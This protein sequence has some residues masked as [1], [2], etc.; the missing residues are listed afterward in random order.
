MHLFGNVSQI[1]NNNRMKIAKVKENLQD[2][3]KKLHCRRDELKNLWLQGL[4]YKHMLQ[5]LD[6]M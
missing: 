3:K 1:V 5:L 2:C 6:E 4:E